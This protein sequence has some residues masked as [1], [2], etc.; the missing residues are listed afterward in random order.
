M[1]VQVKI[2]P[3]TKAKEFANIKLQ[4][5]DTSG[6]TRQVDLYV[7]FFQMYNFKQE[8]KSKAFDF[9]LI[10]TLVYGVDCLLDR[11]EFSVDAWSREI[12]IDFPVVNIHVWKPLEE[13]FKE[14]LSFLTGDYWKITFSKSSIAQFYKPDKSVFKGYSTKSKYVF[15]SLFSG[16]L[17][18][19]IGVINSLELTA[20]GNKTLL[21]SHSDPTSPGANS[22]QVRLVEAIKNR[23]PKLYDW[24]QCK[25]SLE[26]NDTGGRELSKESSFRSRS[27]LFL[28]IGMYCTEGLPACNQLL[29]PEN[30]T[31]SVNFPLTPS[32]SST[33]STRT[34][35]PHY[36]QLLQTLLGTAGFTTTI[37][38]P[39]K[40]MTKGEM[41]VLPTSKPII[42]SM[43]GLSVSCGKRGRKMHWDIKVGTSHCGVCMPCIY[44]R[45]SLHQMG[46]DTQLYGID[47]FKTAKPVLSIPDMPAFFDFI[48]R[49]MKRT[50]IR[51]TLIVN[52]SFTPA[53]AEAYAY[54]VERVRDE[55][56]IWLKA[57]GNKEIWKL[58]GI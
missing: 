54:L 49:P 23:Y 38:N 10:S 37:E 45:A 11:Y 9:F 35:H 32:R 15:S 34:T 26:P 6:V 27:L 24:V 56:K 1:K 47:I 44:R 8:T 12:E 19:L 29:I 41:V 33:L 7:D 52:G 21:I 57:K 48:K 43:Y 18:S 22:D 51:R 31:I 39:Y 58:A 50:T 17:D 14:L 20:S 55:I 25:V 2:T 5:D 3:P 4:F 28:G 42:T 46:A 40:F 16:G 13:D 53:D 36:I 30:G